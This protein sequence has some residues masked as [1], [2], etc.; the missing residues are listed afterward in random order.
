MRKFLNIIL[1]VCSFAFILT[2]FYSC[3]GTSHSALA[4]Q[5]LSA[6]EKAYQERMKIKKMYGHQIEVAADKMAHRIQRLIAPQSGREVRYK[7]DYKNLGYDRNN[8]QV[9]IYTNFSFLARDFLSGVDYGTCLI[10]GFLEVYLPIREIDGTRATFT[11]KE[12]NKQIVSVSSS[13]DWNVLDKGLTIS[14]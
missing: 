8:H 13:Y 4:T 3:V 7:L 10:G 14:F 2:T 12:R 11:W 9:T 6:E 1:I 5:H